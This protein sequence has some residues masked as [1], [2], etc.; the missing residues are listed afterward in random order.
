[1]FMFVFRF[2]FFFDCLPKMMMLSY[3]DWERHVY[4]RAFV[5]LIEQTS[6]RLLAFLMSKKKIWNFLSSPIRGIAF[7]RRSSVNQ[8]QS[9]AVTKVKMLIFIMTHLKGYRCMWKRVRK[10]LLFTSCCSTRL[11]LSLFLSTHCQF[12]Y[13]AGKGDDDR[14]FYSAD[15]TSPANKTD[16][17]TFYWTSWENIWNEVC[18]SRE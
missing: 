1:V 5:V 16:S 2:S 15:F 9:D 10:W 4:T 17:Q 14:L 8:K 12:L 13:F 7:E 3:F 18:L 6:L 11:I